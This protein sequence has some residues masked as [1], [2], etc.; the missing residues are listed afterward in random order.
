MALALLLLPSLAAA[1]GLGKL[2][3]LSA[4]GQPLKAEIELVSMQKGEAEN[5]SVRL[6]SA[7]AFRQANID[8]SGALLSVKFSIEQRGVGRY[9]IVLSSTQPMNEPFIDLLVELDWSTGRLVREYTF[10]LD[11]PEY[12]GPQAAPDVAAPA[13]TAAPPIKPAEAPKQTEERAGAP[14][15][16][17]PLVPPAAPAAPAEVA[18]KSTATYQVKRGDTLSRIASANKS[19]SVSLQQMLIA[20]YRGNADAFDGNNINRLRT[21]KILNIPDKDAA[22]SVDH[23]DAIRLVIAQEADF[24][25]YRRKLGAA[26]AAAPER[27]D[28]RRQSASGKITASVEDKPAA[29]KAATD[30]L[31]LSKTEELGKPG[32][33]RSPQG[34]QEDLI[35]KQKEIQEANER[36][37]MLEKNVQ[38]MQK[39]LELKSQSGAQ[40]QQQ[41]A[42]AGAAKVADT[43]AK[44]P[45]APKAGPV[46][47]PEPAKESEP[48]KAP[49]PA[50][51]A[52]PAKASEPA[53]TSETAKTADV[54]KSTEPAKPAEPATA[55]PKAAPKSAKP[56]PPPPEP[57][58][59][60][61]ILDSELALYG[62]GGFLL[63]L[64]CGY[65]YYA[66]RRKKSLQLMES[67]LMGGP[68]LAA[69]SVLGAAGGPKISAGQSE[70][71]SEFS[72]GGAVAA[73]DTEEV[74]P[75]AEADVYMAYGRDIQ[76]EEILKEALAK[77]PSRQAIRAK[78]LEIYAGR[79][80][81]RAFATVAAQISAATG[82]TGPEWEKA[83]A[84]GSLLD[85]GNSLYGNAAAAT[86]SHLS[87]QTQILS[88]ADVAA[89]A[90][91][92][93]GAMPDSG[94]RAA[95]STGLDFDLGLGAPT[96]AAAQPN[97]A[98]DAGPVH[99]GDVTADLEFDLDLGGDEKA[100][101][102]AAGDTLSLDTKTQVAP[103]AA[104]SIDFDFELPMVGETAQTAQA[105]ASVET[106]AASA[107]GSSDIDFDF[108]LDLPPQNEE[109][110]AVPATP[111]DL[112]LVNLDLGSPM[113]ADAPTDAHWQEVATKL[114]LAKAYQEMGDKDGARQLL[115]EVLKEG[116][117]AQQQQ[118]QTML[119]A[120]G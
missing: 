87:T 58:L 61:E 91:A 24:N 26:V 41:A 36:I 120:L 4:L 99:G 109:A 10:L 62:G 49:E 28:T 66:W 119:S 12:K 100:P 33:K 86:V 77:D 1:A 14:M 92:S 75:I 18:P 67:S 107:G 15:L 111:L 44:V 21:G 22:A 101:D 102:A 34:L 113:G 25:E 117:A 95:V 90:A 31:K 13:E 78:L 57:S 47:V 63:L 69:D 3:V 54:A 9:V 85:P 73:I 72:Q 6:P 105:Q 55:A 42:K 40:L 104:A 112:S 43:A 53:K 29:A 118:A 116:D 45:E 50:K 68:S 27:A 7:D 65:G 46:K 106:P 96:V 114:D 97:I 110:P 11:P 74:D 20:L 108:N 48:T 93:S 103:D 115:N 5:L 84:L 32:A 39:L 81:A 8:Y 64:F 88:A 94:V 19:S 89:A 23:A 59:I 16:E 79:K 71:Q 37:A 76:A 98:P 82:G 17:K 30:Q 38:D 35:T 60:D 70:I 52:E 2:T 83:V 56:S 51:A 80:D